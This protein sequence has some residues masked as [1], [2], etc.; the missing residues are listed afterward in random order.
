MNAAVKAKNEGTQKINQMES[1][2]LDLEKRYV[3]ACESY[4]LEVSEDSDVLRRSILSL[5]KNIPERFTRIVASLVKLTKV[6]TFYGLVAGDSQN[7]DGKETF[8]GTIGVLR[9]IIAHGDTSLQ[10][11]QH[12]LGL[13]SEITDDTLQKIEKNKYLIYNHFCEHIQ[14]QQA[15]STGKDMTQSEVIE[16]EWDQIREI[17]RDAVNDTAASTELGVSQSWEIV[18]TTE[19]VEAS[20]PS[21]I[22]DLEQ[23]CEFA[24]TATIL[25]D[26]ELR[27]L[28]IDDLEELECYLKQRQAEFTSKDQS[29][30]A[31]FQEQKQ[32]SSQYEQLRVEI[33]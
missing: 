12:A 25:Y 20:A 15:K 7:D 29:F 21:Q 14:A 3:E 17:E 13:N 22:V 31:V 19:A 16:I 11:Y 18:D 27:Q 1:N 32:R 33:D 6:A 24:E 5:V 9:Y 30:Y 28:L 8:D 26:T 10:R 2:I 4:N 23:V